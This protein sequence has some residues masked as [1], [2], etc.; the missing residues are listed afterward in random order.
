[1]RKLVIAILLAGSAAKANAC[2]CKPLPDVAGALEQSD[3]VADGTV[4]A[5]EDQYVGWRR[6]KGWFQWR[7]GPPFPTV[8]DDGFAVTFRAHATWKGVFGPEFTL[9]TPRHPNSCGLTLKPGARYVVYATLLD[10]DHY[11]VSVCSRTQPRSDDEI[12]KLNGLS[13][14]RQF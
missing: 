14:S 10:T 6:I 8:L 12:G 9:Y 3:L 13:S 7:F 1:M 4:L 2:S 11:E 5:V